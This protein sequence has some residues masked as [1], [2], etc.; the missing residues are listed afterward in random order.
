[1]EKGKPVPG[2]WTQAFNEVDFLSIQRP[3]FFPLPKWVRDWRVKE[4][5]SFIIQDDRLYLNALLGNLKEFCM[6][7]VFLYDKGTGERMLFRKYLPFNAWRMPQSLSNSS[8]ESRFYGFFFRIHDWLDAG[9]IRVDFDI[10]ATRKRPSFTAHVEYDLRNITPL[11][12]NLLFSERRGMYAYKALGAVRGD[13]VFSGRHSS[14]DPAG[15]RGIFCDFKGFYPYR[16]RSTWCTGF[17]VDAE[18]RR[19]GFSLAENQAKDTFK[20]NE[21]ALWVDGELSPLPPVR[22][23]MPEGIESPWIIQ[24]ME[25]MV[26]LTFTPKE[27]LRG[28]V[29]PL[30]IHVDYATPLGYF[31][32]ILLNSRGEQIQVRNLWGLGEKLYLRV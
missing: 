19:Y 23:T 29:N 20:N 9:I 13:M 5:E 27:P 31:N 3:F 32:G 4:W 17:G 22:I 30:F 11:V 2:T 6:A 21:N 14:F 25:G 28:A 18:S 10:K 12:V 26:D 24:D 16:M 7:Q 1:M 15:T 8:I